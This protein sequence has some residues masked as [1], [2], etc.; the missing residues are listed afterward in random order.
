MID[1][2]TLDT[3]EQVTDDSPPELQ[4]TPDP[5]PQPTPDL[6][7]EPALHSI[8][9]MAVVEETGTIVR[10][11]GTN[12][13]NVFHV[14]FMRAGGGNKKDGHQYSAAAVEALVPLIQQRRKIF[15]N[16]S[17]RSQVAALGHRPLD[18]LGGVA[19]RESVHYDPVLQATVGDVR[20][21]PVMRECIEAAHAVG[22]SIGV[23]VEAVGIFDGDGKTCVGWRR[24]DSSAFVPEG[25]AGGYTLAVRE[26]DTPALVAAERDF[27]MGFLDNLSPQDVR[28][29]NS[30][31]YD[32]IGQEYSAAH[33]VREVPASTPDIDALVRES[34]AYQDAVRESERLTERLDA[35]ERE[36][37]REQWA[38][39]VTDYVR[40]CGI[41]ADPQVQ[42]IARQFVGATVG[43]PDSRYDTQDEL[44]TAVREAA[45]AYRS[46][47]N[48]PAKGAI[49]G[50][51]GN[52]GVA[53]RVKPKQSD[54]STTVFDDAFA[55]IM[56]GAFPAGDTE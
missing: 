38:G 42:Y 49:T 19:V 50:V 40:E 33:P 10:E 35:I 31:L 11:A 44:E 53:P 2:P 14:Q 46:T 51:G 47:L 13:P 8:R 20:V 34:D 56:G 6:V 7:P 16:H 39:F 48:V 9:E 23:S 5:T 22:D 43:G 27:S 36:R 17:D 24:Y 15:V 12:D 55:R 45:T 28:E 37:N 54:T 26:A 25:G 32:H 18:Q 3:T 52:A 41:D 21:R 4:P 29:S 1:D 30:A